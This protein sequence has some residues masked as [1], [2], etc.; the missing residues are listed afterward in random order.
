VAA[1]LADDPDPV[2]QIYAHCVQALIAVMSV[3]GKWQC[4]PS[5]GYS[6]LQRQLGVPLVVIDGW[7][8]SVA[9][10]CGGQLVV[11]RTPSPAQASSQDWIRYSVQDRHQSPF[12]HD[13]Q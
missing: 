2:T 8:E 13:L 4:S 5:E 9:A 11:S 1:D 12:R 6:V 3:N 10:R 7:R